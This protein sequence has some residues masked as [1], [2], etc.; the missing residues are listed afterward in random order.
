[1]LADFLNSNKEVVV[2]A[3][4]PGAAVEEPLGL[5]AERRTR[6]EAILEE[7]IQAL[8]GGGMDGPNRTPASGRDTAVDS[9]V[10]A[11][12]RREV[13][14]LVEQRGV[15]ATFREGMIVSDWASSADR[16]K[17][18]EHDHWLSALLD[19]VNDAAIIFSTEGRIQYINGAGA[20][21]L[22]DATGVPPDEILGK[23][24][25]ELAA[26]REL[27]FGLSPDELV[28]KARAGASDES[29]RFGRWRD[30]TFGAVYTPDGT[31]DAVTVVSRDI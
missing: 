5:A 8:R 16:E 11:L 21:V 20:T 18:R 2:Q 26:P 3:V 22:H 24:G 14:E 17:L 19:G 12:L 10:R 15:Q 31:L 30:R 27:A 6:L 23:T 1:M 25:A 29:H 28:A 13:T 4:E 7:L 9:R